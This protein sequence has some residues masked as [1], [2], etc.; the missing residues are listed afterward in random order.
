MKVKLNTQKISDY[1]IEKNLTIKE[2]S[3]TSEISVYILKK[4]FNGY[5]NIKGD[6]IVKLCRILKCSSSELLIIE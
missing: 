1:M 4:I 3:K 6:L 5:S 2:F